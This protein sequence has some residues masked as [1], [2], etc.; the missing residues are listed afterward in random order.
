MAKEP[1]LVKTTTRR[2]SSE[3]P[4]LVVEGVGT[5]GVSVRPIH[6]FDRYEAN[7][8]DG[9][10]IQVDRVDPSSPAE[11]AGLK[12][13]DIIV[14][15]DDQ[16]VSNTYQYKALIRLLG[17]GHKARFLVKSCETH[18]ERTPG[19]DFRK[20]IT[21]KEYLA[22]VTIGE[23]DGGP[24]VDPVEPFDWSKPP[25]KETVRHK[26]YTVN[27]RADG[28]VQAINDEGLIRFQGDGIE[29]AK[30]YLTAELPDQEWYR[31]FPPPR[32]EVLSLG[33]DRV[34]EKPKDGE[35]KQAPK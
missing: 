18:V 1:G 33:Y 10:G 22:E 17:P 13:G 31:L 9:I 20:L 16:W 30:W 34:E 4:Q 11:R 7:I 35:P 6:F 8:P 29:L 32:G 12:E 27:F 21:T 23:S 15:I 2:W 14:K 28:S 25:P 19:G 5:I 26:G 3:G 24:L